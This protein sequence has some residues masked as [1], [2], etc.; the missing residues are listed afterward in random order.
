MR[1]LN[2]EETKGDEENEERDEGTAKTQRTQRRDEDSIGPSSPPYRAIFANFVSL[3]FSRRS[4][5]ISPRS[6]SS[7]VS[8]CFFRPGSVG[9]VPPLCALCL[10]T[11]SSAFPSSTYAPLSGHRAGAYTSPCR[12]GGEAEGQ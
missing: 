11:H 8:S 3:R 12:R 6:S 7:F 5:F 2:H 1:R 9:S 4:S 10:K